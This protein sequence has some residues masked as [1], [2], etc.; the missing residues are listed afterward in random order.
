MLT[1]EAIRAAAASFPAGTGLGVDNISPRALLRLSDEA[2]AALASLLMAIERHGE[3]PPEL[4]LVLIVLLAKS[5]GGF[6][7]IGLFPTLIR[8]WMRART[9]QARAWEAQNHSKEIFGGRGMGAQ[10][11][12]WVESFNA[13]AAGLE[14]EEQAQA[15]LDLTKAFELV[16]H[17]LLF[18]AAKKRGYPLAVLRLSLAAYRL[19]RT[20]GIDGCYSREVKAQRGITAGSGFAT[21]EL[22]LLLMDV[23]EATRNDHWPSVK[24][25]LYVDD[26]TVSIRGAAKTVARRLAAAVDADVQAFQSLE[27]TVSV[28]KSTVVASSRKLAIRV[29]RKSKAKVLSHSA[30]AKLLGT[31]ASGGRRRS[32]KIAR[33]RL[34]KFRE[35][36]RK[37]GNCGKRGRLPSRWLALRAPLR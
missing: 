8:V 17:E 13:E 1:V 26:L 36:V 24:L 11:A 3:W 14:K 28:S 10:R 25:T 12:A 30:Q 32:T 6:R 4:H 18:E 20:I 31:A 7:P 35:C 9:V 29:C 27:L 22:R 16:D 23:L 15:L 19:P 2:L 34:S 33:S 5:D 37:C 21:T